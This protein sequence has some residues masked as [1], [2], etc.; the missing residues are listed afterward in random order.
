VLGAEWRIFRFSK[1]ETSLN[2]SF[3]L[4]PSLTESGR[5]RSELNITLSREL[6]EDLTFDLSYYNS[7]DSDPPDETASRSDYGVVTSLGY[8]F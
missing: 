5:Y 6:I 2:S 1:P 7:Y 4:Y 3:L 8:K